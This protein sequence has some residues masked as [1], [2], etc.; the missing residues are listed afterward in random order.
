MSQTVVKKIILA[1]AILK[2]PK[3]LI[4]ENA[5]DQIDETE[6][7]SIIDFLASKSNPWGLLIVSEDNYWK[8]QCSEIFKLKKGEASSKN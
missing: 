6:K 7:K 5:L 4:L 1:R 8:D 2:N 3:L